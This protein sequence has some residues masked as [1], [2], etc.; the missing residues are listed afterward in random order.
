MRLI[1]THDIAPHA[2][3]TYSRAY[4]AIH[5]PKASFYRPQID[6]SFLFPHFFPFHYVHLITP[7][8]KLHLFHFILPYIRHSLSPHFL[9]FVQPYLHQKASPDHPT[10]HVLTSKLSSIDMP[11]FSK[12]K[13]GPMSATLLSRRG[14]RGRGAFPK[15]D[16]M[17]NQWSSSLEATFPINIF[18][19]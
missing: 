10:W 13:F 12:K 19:W 17:P 3:P 2:M 6:I 8:A 14:G 11:S 16:K 18:M 15:N 5:C 7:K 4:R 1:N 9:I